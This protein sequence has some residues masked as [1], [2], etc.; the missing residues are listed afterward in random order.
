MVSNIA[1]SGIIMT[2]SLNDGSPYYVINYDDESGRTDLVTGG[3]GVHKTVLIH[4]DC[5]DSY[6][7]SKRVYKMVSLAREVEKMCGMEPLD[8]EFCLDS[9]G[10]MNVLQVRRIS[11][12]N[13]WHPDIEQR[14]TREL[15]HVEKFVSQRMMPWPKLVGSKTILGNMSDWNPA[16]IIGSLPS[17]LSASL[18][19]ELITKSVWRNSREQMG[20]RSLPPEELMVLISGRPYT[21]LRCSFNSLLPRELDDKVAS[22]LVNAWLNYLDQKPELHDKIEFEVTQT[23]L[24]FTFED[25]FKYRYS[26]LLTSSQLGHFKTKLHALTNSCLKPGE[27]SSLEKNLKII[28]ILNTKQIERGRI[29]FKELNGLDK[30]SQINILLKECKILGTIPFSIIARHAFIGET[31]LRSGVSR[32]AISPERLLFFKSTIHTVM[33]KFAEDL[34]SVF[35]EVI[36]RKE[37]MERYGHLR[38]GT[39]DILSPCYYDR[40][41]IFNNCILPEENI[42][43]E[44][45][46]ISPAEKRSINALLKEINISTID[47][48]GLFEYVRKGIIGR[49]YAKFVFTRNLSEALE[50]IAAWG[51]TLGL[52]RDD[53]SY[54]KLPSILEILTTSLQYDEEEHF[55]KLVENE[56]HSHMVNE[57]VKLSY[58]IRGIKDLYVVPLHRSVP[59]YITNKRVE[60][61]MIFLCAMSS[62]NVDLHKKV[63]CIENAD[64]GFDW[65]FTRG[66]KGLITKY[67]GLN[68][69]MAIRCA[70]I[71]LPGALGVGEQLFS[72]LRTASVV[73]LNCGDKILRPLTLT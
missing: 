28:D 68:S 61:E 53:L 10:E 66:I 60:G 15:P 25:T 38:S 18:Y 51:E 34:K 13:N 50:G 57:S 54:I 65:I 8:I 47:S 44:P 32:G 49:E 39:Y 55:L 20:Y 22:K 40:E 43:K 2:H 11:V 41:E 36:N 24:D 33:G 30:L 19:R 31:L 35:Q 1:V 46:L 21:D 14:V 73:E 17:P 72:Q 7:D 6:I 52:Q 45:F 9:A 48:E 37:F 67:G 71:G 62:Y 56:R 4:R 5:K 12:S 63:V 64:P 69:H 16:E 23:I 42:H 59:N 29:N 27:E 58:I 26:G 3:K 70:E